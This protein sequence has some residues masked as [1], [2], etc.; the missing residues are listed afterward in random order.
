MA[1][2]ET[3]W[4]KARVNS[5]RNKVR[6]LLIFTNGT[7]IPRSELIRMAAQKAKY[8]EK[9]PRR[10]SPFFKILWDHY[11][12]ECDLY[13]LLYE[14]PKSVLSESPVLGRKSE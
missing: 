14:V 8:L 4:D 6:P 3:T 13:V 12:P 9:C 10:E 7:P 2:H 1:K 5:L 11:V